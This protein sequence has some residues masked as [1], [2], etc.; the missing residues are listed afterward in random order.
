M[1]QNEYNKLVVVSESDLK[2]FDALPGQNKDSEHITV[3]AN[4]SD[5]DDETEYVEYEN[6][7]DILN[8]YNIYFK[9]LFKKDHSSTLFD[10][11]DE[12]D[13]LSTNRALEKFYDELFKY[14]SSP[15]KRFTELYDPLEYREKFLI[16]EPT[17]PEHYPFYLLRIGSTEKVSHNLLPILIYIA[18]N[19]WHNTEWSINQLADF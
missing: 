11:I 6:Y 16:K 17:L 15:S 12:T 4:E 5:D 1:D 9:T 7:V 18:S 3:D 13:E 8:I 10:D 14:K 2:D 19:D